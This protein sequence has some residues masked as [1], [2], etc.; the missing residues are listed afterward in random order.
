MQELQQFYNAEAS[1]IGIDPYRITGGYNYLPPT[2]GQADSLGLG[3]GGGGQG[4]P[5]GLGIGGGQRD[6]LGLGI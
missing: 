1:V 5:L 2:S 6:P 4:D 3:I